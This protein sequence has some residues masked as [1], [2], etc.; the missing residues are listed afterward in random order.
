MLAI[1]KDLL[2]P[3]LGLLEADW[4]AFVLLL[5]PAGERCSVKLKA[6][7]GPEAY[8]PRREGPSFAR[9]FSTRGG[10]D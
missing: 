6:M 1:R 5:Q 8:S 10:I 3:G 2:V 7:H 9:S 4:S